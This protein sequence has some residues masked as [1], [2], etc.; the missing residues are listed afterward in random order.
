MKNHVINIQIEEALPLAK[1][2]FLKTSGIGLE[3]DK[4]KRMWNRA[5]QVYEDVSKNLQ[6]QAVLSVY[7]PDLTG[8]D[9]KIN[10]RIFSCNGFEQLEHNC[11]FR[12]Y[13]Y[14]LTAGDFKVNSDQIVDQ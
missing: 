5:E 3:T 1:L 2:Y 6:L 14:I 10:G 9:M 4:H 12:V 11:L 8:K 13:A 7:S